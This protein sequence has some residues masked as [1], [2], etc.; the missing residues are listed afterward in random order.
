LVSKATY[1]HVKD[2]NLD[3]SISGDCVKCL[4]LGKVLMQRNNDRI[5]EFKTLKEAKEAGSDG[6]EVWW[7]KN[8]VE[9]QSAESLGKEGDGNEGGKR[10]GGPG[11]NDDEDEKRGGKKRKGG[12]GSGAQQFGM[13][14]KLKGAFGSGK[15]R[16]LS[17]VLNMLR[18]LSVS[19]IS[20]ENSLNC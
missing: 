2:R 14:G 7:V 19:I 6:I 5:E 9:K 18:S 13:K 8:S 11:G 17:K 20:I 10:S 15:T 12:G 16:G 3:L 1:F 4:T